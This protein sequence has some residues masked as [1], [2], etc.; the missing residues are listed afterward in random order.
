MKILDNL[1]TIF[2][3]NLVSLVKEELEKRVRRGEVLWEDAYQLLLDESV[4]RIGK[5]INLTR[6]DRTGKID[7][8]KILRELALTKIYLAALTIEAKNIDRILGTHELLRKDDVKTIT[9]IRRRYLDIVNHSVQ[10][11]KT[12]NVEIRDGKIRLF[13]VLS[14]AFDVQDIETTFIPDSF[15]DRVGNEPT[16]E[17][18]S[19]GTDSGFWESTIF[20]RGNQGASAILTLD[21]KNTVS[22]N[23]LRINGAGK[24]PVTIT[25]VEILQGDTFTSIH[26]GNV[27]NKSINIIYPDINQTSKVRLTVTQDIGQYTWFTFVDNKRD[28]I[29]EETAEEAADESLNESIKQQEY[30]PVV[31]KRLDNVYAFQMGAF[32]I[33]LYLDIFSGDTDGRF[34]SRKFTSEDPIN[35]IELSKDLAEF[36]PGSSTIRYNIIQ[37][38]GSRV[39]ISPDE[40]LIIDKEFTTTQ[41]LTD[42]IE[43]QVTLTSAPLRDGLTVTVNGETATL[44][45]EFSGNGSLEFLINGRKLFFS[46]PTEDTTVSATY[47]H[48]TDFFIVE[49]ILNNGT[50]ENQ[51]NTPFVENFGVLINGSD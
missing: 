13:P 27:T 47:N 19:T 25:D 8:K 36:K 20:T 16:P 35:T 41:T 2:D 38:D 44:V 15:V 28:L 7:R 48:K 51:F 26:T 42:G 32:N 23:R 14:Q 43:N 33:L 3:E 9:D 22:F 31:E 34:F 46:V 40:V 45:D 4:N 1:R 21:F 6:Q 5:D 29:R 11:F 50:T 18:I 10:E 24:F 39:T 30:I 17:N 49:I 37:Q 12:S